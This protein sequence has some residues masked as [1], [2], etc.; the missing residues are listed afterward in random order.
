MVLWV[1]LYGKLK[2]QDGTLNDLA[3]A[4]CQRLSLSRVAIVTDVCKS[5]SC[6]SDLRTLLY[7]VSHK[8]YSTLLHCNMLSEYIILFVQLSVI[9]LRTFIVVWVHYLLVY[10]YL[11][12]PFCLLVTLKLIKI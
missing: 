10:S 2:T 3:M 6:I 1:E 11:C 5:F 8:V 7:L 12:I 9:Y 4:N